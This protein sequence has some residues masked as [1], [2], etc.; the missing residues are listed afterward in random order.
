MYT[1]DTLQ[2]KKVHYDVKLA[3]V[4]SKLSSNLYNSSHWDPII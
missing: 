2:D 4:W 1:D 3:E